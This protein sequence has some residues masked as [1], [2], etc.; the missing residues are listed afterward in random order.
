MLFFVLR[1]RWGLNFGWAPAP[2]ID[3]DLEELAERD[4]ETSQTCIGKNRKGKPCGAKAKPG[5]QHPGV[6]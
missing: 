4:L 3:E 6:L 5:S 1:S 2:A